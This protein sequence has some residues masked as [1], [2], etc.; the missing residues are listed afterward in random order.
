MEHRGNATSSR[1]ANDH[2][3]DFMSFVVF[4]VFWLLITASLS[5]DNILR[6]VIVCFLV[7]LTARL[8]LHTRLPGDI[9]PGFLLVRF[10][11]FLVLLGWEVIKAN[12]NLAYILLKPRLEIDPAVVRVGTELRG[13]F[14]KT[15][16]A[17]SITVTPGTLT[18]DARDNELLVHCLTPAHKNGLV[19][20]RHC[21]RLVL[22]LFRQRAQRTV[23]E[24]IS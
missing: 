13:D 18:I 24:I 10:P 9:T 3:R 21:E 1:N 20:R 6:G 2:G 15:V 7:T 5:W 8:V 17:D 14:R 4:F 23:Q 11:V 12:I 22:R 16:L 19:Q